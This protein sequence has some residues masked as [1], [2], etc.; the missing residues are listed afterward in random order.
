MLVPNARSAEKTELIFSPSV[1]AML[2]AQAAEIFIRLN[3]MKTV[4]IQ[5]YDRINP[6]PYPGDIKLGTYHRKRGQGLA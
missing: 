2:P 5:E 4:I 3:E 1:R 6:K